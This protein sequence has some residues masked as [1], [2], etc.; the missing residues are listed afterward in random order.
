MRRFLLWR[1]DWKIVMFQN[2]LERTP[3][4]VTNNTP[5]LSRLRVLWWPRQIASR[6]CPFLYANYCCPAR[7]PYAQTRRCSTYY[8]FPSSFYSILRY[9]KHTSARDSNVL[10]EEGYSCSFTP[11]SLPSSRAQ[12]RRGKAV[13]VICWR[14]LE[15]VECQ[16]HPPNAAGCHHRGEPVQQLQ[17]FLM[18]LFLV[19][20][21]GWN[22]ERHTQGP[23]PHNDNGRTSQDVYRCLGQGGGLQYDVDHRRRKTA[24]ETP[25]AESLAA[26]N[27]VP[28]PR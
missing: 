9:F 23:C 18:E 19:E 25:S 1:F 21:L 26:V 14:L 13:G 7:E 4:L 12:R 11:G 17:D 8:W 15:V 28:P 24:R 22:G 16:R 6:I 27:Q 2:S 10:H 3:Q 20:V 5:R